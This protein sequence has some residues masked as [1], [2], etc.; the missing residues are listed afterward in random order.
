M[1]S[2]PGWSALRSEADDR[3]R[4]EADIQPRCHV[5]WVTDVWPSEIVV[6]NESRSKACLGTDS[7]C[8]GL[9]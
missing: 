3:Y 2:E 9:D 5:R 7:E 1:P 8:A 6:L 4:P